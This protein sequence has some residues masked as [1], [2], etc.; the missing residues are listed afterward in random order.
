M[1]CKYMDVENDFVDI[2][3]NCFGNHKQCLSL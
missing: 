3:V 1:L 2:Q